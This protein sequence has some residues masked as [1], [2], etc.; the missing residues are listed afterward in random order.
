MDMT[1]QMREGQINARRQEKWAERI[2]IGSRNYRV[3]EKD[4]VN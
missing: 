4:A 3:K 1:G 2:Q